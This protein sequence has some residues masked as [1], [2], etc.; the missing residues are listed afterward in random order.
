MF[1]YVF[2]CNEN[3]A[4]RADI[5]LAQKNLS[6][7]LQLGGTAVYKPCRPSGEGAKETEIDSQVDKRRAFNFTGIIAPLKESADRNST[8]SQVEFSCPQ[9]LSVQ[10]V[11][12]V[13]WYK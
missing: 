13:G 3:R 6:K 1:L 7:Y 2:Q 11:V 10:N 5:T 8:T 12:L 4:D 9:H